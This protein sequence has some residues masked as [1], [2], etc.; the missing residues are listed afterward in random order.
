MCKVSEKIKFCSCSSPLD[1]LKHYWVLHRFVAGKHEIVVGQPIFSAEIEE[2]IDNLNKEVLLHRMNE[3]DAFDVDLGPKP[4]DRLLISLRCGDDAYGYIH[5]GF[6]YSKNGKW[7][8]EQYDT[9][10]WMWRH[11]E[12]QFGKLVSPLKRG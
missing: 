4:K 11:E 9:F 8:E 12:A 3:P 10:E 6:R 2:S 7:V 1:K 5:Y